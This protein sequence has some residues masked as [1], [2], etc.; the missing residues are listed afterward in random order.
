MIFGRLGATACRRRV[1][2]YGKGRDSGKSSTAAKEG[3]LN[4][5]YIVYQK[6]TFDVM[7]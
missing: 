6:Y 2:Q 5:K 4:N 3:K 1:A 7:L